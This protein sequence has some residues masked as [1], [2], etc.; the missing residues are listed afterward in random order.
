MKKKN[1][2]FKSKLT[3][4]CFAMA[5][6][7]LYGKY[8]VVETEIEILSATL[9]CYMWGILALIMEMYTHIL[10]KLERKK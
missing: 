6:L 10:E 8:F 5:G 7:F 9:S 4:V 3:W 1:K 2:I